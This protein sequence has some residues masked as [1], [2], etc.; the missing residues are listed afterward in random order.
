MR[1]QLIRT[2]I[3]AGAILLNSITL[4][5]AQDNKFY[6]AVQQ[7]QFP[8]LQALLKEED[9]SAGAYLIYKAVLLNA[10]GK[11]DSSRLLLQQV[12]R[13]VVQNNDTLGYLY[14]TTKADNSIKLFK[15]DDAADAYTRLSKHYG[16]FDKDDNKAED[17]ESINMWQALKNV[18]PQTISQP[19]E[20]VIQLRKDKANLWNINV[21]ANDSVHSFIFDSGAGMS[22][23]TESYASL[24]GLKIVGKGAYPVV[25]GITG[26]VTRAK[27]GIAD[28]LKIGEIEVRNCVFLVFPDSS[29]SFGNGYYKLNGIIGFPVIKEMGTLEFVKN[30][31][32]I[33]RENATNPYYANMTL[34]GLKPV[35]YL[36]HA[37]ELLPFTFDTG[38]QTSDLS[39]VFYN[40]YKMV[41]DK[42]GIVTEKRVG[43]ASGAKTMKAVKVPEIILYCMEQKVVLKEANIMTEMIDT[44]RDIYYGNIGQDVIGQFEK[45]IIDFKKSYIRLEH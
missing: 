27:L 33:K 14:Y 38:A 6:N 15:Y 22:V 5:F 3:V 24:L 2:V 42:I 23:I 43:G 45:M 29:L 9:F 20:T 32:T 7:K 12:R 8:A 10:F 19:A 18:K 17:K 41:L 11:A 34:D 35:I 37:D 40:K 44:N 26:A 25:S 4:T 21:T 39:D 28:K 30:T 13:S 16:A 1:K 31:L 36:Q